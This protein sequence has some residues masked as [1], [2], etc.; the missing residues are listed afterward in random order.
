MAT[1][2]ADTYKL[3]PIAPE[4]VDPAGTVTKMPSPK[5]MHHVHIFSDEN[6][7]AMVEFYQMIFN[8]E[9]TNVNSHENRMQLTFITYDDHDHRV[10]VI[11]RPGWGTKPQNPVGLSHIAFAYSSLG[12]LLFIYKTLKAAGHPAPHWTVNHG[13]ST[14]F[15]YRDPDGNEVETMMDN[16]SS[17]DTQDYKRF[18][19][20]TEEFGEMSEGNFDPDKMLELYES[21][22]P[23]TTLLDREEVRRMAREGVL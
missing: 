14:S 23:D 18:Y 3:K 22:V 17:L 16:F 21:G 10:V 6:Y 13:N 19:Q 4:R 9:I 8:G 5:E 2:A 1:K 7:D 20:F 15:Y 12:E 11:K